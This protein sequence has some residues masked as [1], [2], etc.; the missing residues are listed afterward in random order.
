MESSGKAFSEVTGSKN[1][2]IGR[3][4]GLVQKDARGR[5]LL[6]LVMVAVSGPIELAGIG[7]TADL[8]GLVA[9][10][11]KTLSK[12]PLSFILEH[13][14][15][16]DPTSRLKEGLL[17]AILTLALVHG[18]TVMKSYFRADFV[19]IQE[20][21]VSTR[22][23]RAC[24]NQPY[25]WFLQRNSAELHR[26]LSSGGITQALLNSFVSATAKMAVAVTLTIAMIV[27]EPMVA[28]AA[29]LI[30]CVAYVVVRLFTKEALRKRGGRAHADESARRV[31]AQEAL[32]SIR[33]VK[34]TARE[35][36]FIKRYATFSEKASRGMVF[37]SI[38]VDTVRAFL[39]WIAFGC[40]LTFSV[41][42]VLQADSLEAILPRLTLFTMAS[43]RVIPAVHELFG[44][45]SNFKFNSRFLDDIEE[46]MALDPVAF[47]LQQD[48]VQGLD[49]SESLIVLND[50][51]YAYPGTARR[52][53]KD[54]SFQLPRGSWLGVVG[55]TGAGKTT[56]LD[57]LS[58]LC[59][60]DEGKVCV[61]QSDLRPEVVKSWQ[62]RI[63]VVPQEVILLDDSLLRNVAFGVAPDDIDES[64]VKEVVRLAGLEHLVAKMPDGLQ[65]RLG[66]RGTRLSGGERQRVGLARALYRK[67]LLLLLD[68]ATSAL[69]QE[70][71]A[72]IIETLKNL[73]QDC[74][75][76]TV[77]HRLSSVQPC[78]N[79]LVLEDGELVSQG[80]FEELLQNSRTFQRLAL[81]T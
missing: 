31:T 6:L 80:S 21:A 38:Y 26:L 36:F 51:S 7:V 13:Q 50:V 20:T 76:V 40:L 17:L 8:M 63:G 1:S 65:T 5:F 18:Y 12:G 47:D 53:L 23:F 45:W 29:L 55:P 15:V 9:S 19:C 10:Q 56:F 67:P 32:T 54:I 58:G 37:H 81:V 78:E 66:E 69:D 72:R 52:V 64:L 11:G 77:A 22:L 35:D 39:E 74:T 57:L 3:L 73:A 4:W 24:L 30:V 41:A 71:E 59:F 49:D 62:S 75:L 28:V 33:F 27:V 16:T 70:T 25:V 79:I 68:E 46:L 48:S 60:P 43:Y 2:V 14:Q 61:G 44:L 34:T 42:M